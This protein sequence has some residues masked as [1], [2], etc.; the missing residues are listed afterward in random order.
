MTSQSRPRNIYYKKPLGDAMSKLHILAIDG[1]GMKGLISA[2]VLEALEKKLQFYSGNEEARIADYFDLIAGTSTGAILT[3]LYLKPGKDG[4]PEFSA[5]DAKNLYL[6]R[7][8]DIFSQSVSHY[9]ATLGGLTG[10]KYS[11]KALKSILEQ[12]LGNQDIAHLVKPCLM[13]SYDIYN[14][15]AHFFDSFSAQ[16]KKN[17]N[18]YVKEAVLASS[19]APTFFPPVMVTSM[20]GEKKCMID[21]GICAN[22]PAMCAFTEIMKLSTFHSIQDVHILSIGNAGNEYE[23]SCKNAKNWGIIGWSIPVVHTVMNAGKQVTDYE[24]KML[25]DTMKNSGNYIR[26]EKKYQKQVELPAM[27]D[28]SQEALEILTRIGNEMMKEN[29]IKLEILAKSL[30]GN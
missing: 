23:Y 18:Y 26:I 17:K 16:K 1:G 29:D 5:E 13:V 9:M 20:S 12:Y 27:D 11:N 4:R 24:L 19:A 3:A 14:A 30:T 21:G 2:M 15:S 6:E 7:G 28:S 22:N 10:P 25:Y 8:K